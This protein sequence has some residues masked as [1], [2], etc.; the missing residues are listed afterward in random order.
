MVKYLSKVVQLKNEVDNPFA[1]LVKASFVLA[2]YYFK[3]R[4]YMRALDYL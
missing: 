1:D 4:H 2:N 3:E